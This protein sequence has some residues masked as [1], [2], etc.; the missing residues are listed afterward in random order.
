MS[1][2][3]IIKPEYIGAVRWF[4]RGYCGE[5]GCRDAACC[6]SLCGQPIGAA[7]DDPKWETHDEYCVDCDLCRDQA[8]IMLWRERGKRTEQAQFHIRCF[9]KIIF[10]PNRQQSG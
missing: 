1:S 9:E 4:E 5:A 3:F 2:P 6:C 7:D 10:V 8:P